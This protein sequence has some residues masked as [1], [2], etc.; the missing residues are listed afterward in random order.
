[1]PRYRS[2]FTVRD[3]LELTVELSGHP[4]VTVALAGSR[5]SG[6]RAPGFQD[7]TPTKRRVE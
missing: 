7:V 6:D 3:R 2:R 5:I 4:M 1:M